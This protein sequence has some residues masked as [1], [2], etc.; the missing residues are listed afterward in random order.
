[1]DVQHHSAL[2]VGARVGRYEL[3]AVLGQGGFGITYRAY[4]PHLKRE[5][6]IK[7]YLPVQ[8]AVR[9]D[10]NA[11]VARSTRDAG[12]FEW[13]RQRFLDEAQTLAHLDEA[14]AVVR[15]IDFL[16]AHGTAYFVMPLLKG[17]PLSDLLATERALPQAAIDRFLLPLLEGLE[18]VHA[19]GFLHRDIKPANIM[20]DDAGRPTL[21]DFGAARAA[22][23]DRTQAMTAIYT[24]GYAAP[25]QIVGERQGPFTDIYALAATLYACVTGNPPP[26]AMARVY[27]ESLA[28]LHASSAALP[29]RDAMLAAIDAGLVLKSEERP[30]SIGDWRLHFGRERAAVS[31][32]ATARPTAVGKPEPAAEPSAAG[33]AADAPVTPTDL[34]PTRRMATEIVPE[35]PPSASVTGAD[36]ASRP[37]A[38]PPATSAAAGRHWTWGGVAVSSLVWLVCLALP[39]MVVVA[40]DRSSIDRSEW[41]RGFLAVGALLIGV[42]QRW[43]R[44]RAAPV[45]AV[46]AAGVLS[47]F[48][49]LFLG[50]ELYRRFLPFDATLLVVPAT[51]AAMALSLRHG[52]GVAVVTLVCGTLGPSATDQVVNVETLLVCQVVAS[53]ATLAVARWRSWWWLGWPVLLFGDGVWL[54]WRLFELNKSARDTIAFGLNQA[55]LAALF[56]AATWGLRLMERSAPRHATGAMYTALLLAGGLLVSGTWTQQAWWIGAAC[57]VVLASSIWLSARYRSRH[58]WLAPAPVLAS[59]ATFAVMYRGLW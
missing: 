3:R 34:A 39:V 21:I 38:Q 46:V 6:A 33:A 12:D 37:A 58:S 59:A 41:P 45:Q 13:G 9:Q 42:A 17:R 14:P 29:Y 35:K 57:A 48:I 24:P 47:L 27:R 56:V 10:G 20:I 44:R 36:D 4:D 28:P 25:E 54:A 22:I 5:V 8:L 49:A 15:V 31:T 30:Q 7:E 50:I 52:P 19:A 55:A 26:N 53:G 32:D 2:P 23:V 51:V 18:Q 40:L 16:E 43:Q 11:V 1:M